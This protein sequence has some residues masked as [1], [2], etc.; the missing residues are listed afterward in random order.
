MEKRSLENKFEKLYYSP[1]KRSAY[2]SARSL[3]QELPR[4]ERSAARIWLRGQDAYTLHKPT[5]KRFLRRQTTA[6]GKDVQLQ[7]DLMDVSNMASD[8]DNVRFILMA[9]DVVSRKAYAKQ[10]PSKS[11]ISVAGP[12]GDILDENGASYLQTDKGK[13][14]YNKD[15]SKILEKRNVKH[16]STDDDEVKASMIERLNRSI[17][18]R[19]YRYMTRNGT[20]RY[21]DVLVSVINAYNDSKHSSIGM[22]P[23]EV[24]NENQEIAMLRNWDQQAVRF[25]RAKKPQLAIGDHVR[26]TQ[27]RMPFTRGYTP[28]W[29]R[30]LFVVNAIETE[31]QPVAYRVEDQ[32]GE[33]I[34]GLFYEAELQ[35]VDKP[36]VYRI[37]EILKQQTVRRGGKK[38]FYVKWLGY[39]TS[40]NSW[41]EEDDLEN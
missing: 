20:K 37:E 21:I 14:F 31:A 13:E 26:L 36:D 4:N 28:R 6:G 39:P 3:L 32:S 2:G 24:T 23:N 16:F 5:R 30:E 25:S 41:V 27:R 9:V 8:N 15:V 33:P 7:A 18:D 22:A 10:L 11:G 40:F 29:T 38:R 17:R 34:K 19:L 1:E 35:K 12:L